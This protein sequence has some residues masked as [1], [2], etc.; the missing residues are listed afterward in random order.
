VPIANKLATAT[1][2][3]PVELKVELTVKLQEKELLV[4]K[5][6]S[7]VQPIAFNTVK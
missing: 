1:I 4:V 7:A 2:V 6:R 3:L 5:F